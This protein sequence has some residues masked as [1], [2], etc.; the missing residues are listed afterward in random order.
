MVMGCL[1]L[2]CRLAY[3]DGVSL[4]LLSTRV[5]RCGVF[6]FAVCDHRYSL[7]LYSIP[8]HATLSVRGIFCLFRD[9]K[10][11]TPVLS[12]KL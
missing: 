5:W 10:L 11:V 4:S 12:A 3:G 2:Y 7:L 1:C 6:V 8:L 9:I